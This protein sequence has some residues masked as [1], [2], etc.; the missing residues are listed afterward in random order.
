MYFVP[1]S[2]LESVELMVHALRAASGEV[3]CKQC[4]VRQV[5]MKQCLTIADSV[6][7]MIDNGTLPALDTEPEPEQ[8]APFHDDPA[9]EPNNNPAKK[10][11]VRKGHL[12]VVK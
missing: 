6:Q 10:P 3:D 5:C 9:P 4:P 2:Q 8:H 7:A 11:P 1:L 12:A